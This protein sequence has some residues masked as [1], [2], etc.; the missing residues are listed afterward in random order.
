MVVSNALERFRKCCH[1]EYLHSL[2][3]KHYNQCAE[4][5][6]HHLRVGQLVMVKH[7]NIHRIEWPLGVTTAV[8]P[9]ERGFIRTAEVDEC[10]R[11]SIRSV[12]FLVPL[13][14]DCQREDDAIRQRLCDDNSGNDDDNDDNSSSPVESSSKAWGLGSTT[15]STSHRTPGSSRESSPTTGTTARCDIPTEGDTGTSY[16]PSLPPSPT[17]SVELRP[18]A[19]EGREAGQGSQ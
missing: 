7:N 1:K 4:N 13:E 6:S 15:D 8:Y 2:Q 18:S 14:L 5:P 16:T 3:E 9:D 11:R 12:T 19:S 10:G 17:S